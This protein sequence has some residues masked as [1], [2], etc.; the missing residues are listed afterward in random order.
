VG[1]VKS[2]LF[3]GE[4]VF[5]ATLSGPGKVWIQSLPFS[6]LAGRMLSAAYQKGGGRDEG[7]GARRPRRPD[8]RRPEFL[9][10]NGFV[11][12]TVAGWI[13]TILSS[14]GIVVGAEQLL[15]TRRD[16]LHRWFGYVYVVAMVT[17]DFAILT[18]YR[19]NG[20]F[21][22]FHVGALANLLCIAMALH[23]MLAQSRP[24]Q[25]KIK[26]YMW[27]SWSY[28][29]CWRQRSP[30]SSCA[31]SHCPGAG[32]ASSL[33]CW[34]HPS[35]AWSVPGS[36]SAISPRRF[37]SE[38]QARGSVPAG[39]PG[40]GL[41]GDFRAGDAGRLRRREHR[42]AAAAVRADPAAMHAR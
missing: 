42:G 13:H 22:A 20:H 21:N 26:H 39:G 40:S 2:M 11:G 1:S 3:G 32:R 17:A 27:M 9:M 14:V 41:A 23:P 12:L 10:I 30:S 18:V 19:F 5:L 29:A 37:R 8:F 33:R 6:R 4:G 24:R 35:S 15:R 7:S 28:V 36:S 38:R 25:W 31:P 16:R 34:P